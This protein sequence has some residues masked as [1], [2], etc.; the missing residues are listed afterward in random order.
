MAGMP[1]LVTPYSTSEFRDLVEKVRAHHWDTASDMHEVA[2][3]LRYELRQH[4]RNEGVGR[5]DALIVARAVTRP[6]LRSV[7]LEHA[8]AQNWRHAYAV[9]VDRVVNHGKATRPA[10]GRAFDPKK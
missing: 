3:E 9:Y 4:M 5:A 7:S 1:G 8:I 2:A 10:R 6:L